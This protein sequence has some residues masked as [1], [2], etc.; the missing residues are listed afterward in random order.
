MKAAPWLRINSS[1]LEAGRWLKSNTALSPS[2]NKVSLT[3]F[4]HTQQQQ[5]DSHPMGPLHPQVSIRHNIQN[6]WYY[7]ISESTNTR[8]SSA[9]FRSARRELCMTNQCQSLQQWLTRSNEN[10]KMFLSFLRCWCHGRIYSLVWTCELYISVF[11]REPKHRE[12]LETLFTPLRKVFDWGDV[13]PHW[14]ESEISIIS[15]QTHEL[16]IANKTLCE[17][18]PEASVKP[19]DFWCHPLNFS[20][21]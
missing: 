3:S 1:R 11:H 12:K 8:V 7:L 14:T 15:N 18:L 19:N 13:W 4:A 20:V 17:I 5:H 21:F 9:L 2:V 6:L 10:K 16:W